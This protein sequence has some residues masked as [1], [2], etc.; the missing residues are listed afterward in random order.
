MP[1]KMRFV[2][3]LLLF[4][5]GFASSAAVLAKE[6]VPP[7]GT[8]GAVLEPVMAGEFALQAGKLP[9]AAR[10]YLQ[11]AQ[12]GHDVGLAELATRIALLANDDARAAQALALWQQRAPSSLAMR[13]A[14]ALSLIHI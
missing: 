3:P 1:A 8:T 2:P 12:A 11:A 13:A 10:W 14:Q 6:S 5:A 7:G 9:E 4:V